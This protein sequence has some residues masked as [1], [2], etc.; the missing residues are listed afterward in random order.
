MSPITEVSDDC[1]FH[2]KMSERVISRERKVEKL[3][4]IVFFDVHLKRNRLVYIKIY[5]SKKY[6]L[7]ILM[8]K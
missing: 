8:R 6:F 5:K 3:R 4:E 2:K 1:F 7:L